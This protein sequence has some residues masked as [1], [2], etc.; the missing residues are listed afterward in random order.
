MNP[1]VEIIT[2]P[3]TFETL[4]SV[5]PY[6]MDEDTDLR[7]KAVYALG[8]FDSDKVHGHALAR[9]E[10]PNRGVREAAAEIVERL[11]LPASGPK[12]VSLLGSPHI[13]IRNLAA[14]IL[15]K[16]GHGVVSDLLAGLKTDDQDVR[17]FIVD[18]LGSIGSK[19]AVPELIPLLFADKDDNVVVSTVEALGKI[20]APEA[21][22]PLIRLFNERPEMQFETIEAVGFIAQPV[23]Q[24]FLQKL[25]GKTED[26]L[27]LLAL[28]DALGNSGDPD[29]IPALAGIFGRVGEELDKRVVQALF[30]VGSKSG[31]NVMV[32]CSDVYMHAVLSELKSENQELCDLVGEQIERYP[33]T[34]CIAHLLKHAQDLPVQLL[35]KIIAASYQN[36]EL[37]GQLMPL[38]HH[39]DER[40]SIPA[41]E[42]SG[43]HTPVEVLQGPL[44][45]FLLDPATDPDMLSAAIQVAGYRKMTRLAGVMEKLMN[46]REYEVCSLADQAYQYLT[47]LAD[48]EDG[49]QL[50]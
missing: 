19:E 37:A 16:I 33:Q 22:E 11:P 40:I 13:E 43:M 5:I 9:L 1:M 18:I 15:M 12:L 44:G 24:V 47:S 50:T 32:N 14:K 4:D 36:D 23:G 30:S 3:P 41:L 28:V 17:K 42:L 38:I 26:P 35:E 25:L 6:L 39:P 27:M 46:H 29:A 21:L 8:N 34:P 48:D 10:D 20:A 31:V 45:E 49:T 7:R 2:Q